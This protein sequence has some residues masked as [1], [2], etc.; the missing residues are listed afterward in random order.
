[1]FVS[2]AN[3]DY[4][5][6]EDCG[7]KN[8]LNSSGPARNGWPN[9]ASFKVSTEKRRSCHLWALSI[10]SLPALVLWAH[11][12]AMEAASAPKQTTYKR[13]RPELTPC[14]RIIQ[15]HLNTFISDRDRERRPLPSYVIK[16]FEGLLEYG[17]PAYQCLRLACRSC[18]KEQIVAFSCKKK[19]FLSF[20]LC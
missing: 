1:M 9:Q 15:I 6:C 12:P 8:K 17:I 2:N 18:L 13:R 19:R 3:M 7:W 5:L 11:W 20:M 16:E 14:Y 4:K 10:L